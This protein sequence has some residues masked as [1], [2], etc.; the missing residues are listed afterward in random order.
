MSNFHLFD[1]TNSIEHELSEGTTILGRGQDCDI[2][3]IS[4]SVSRKHAQLELSEG[5]LTFVDLGSSNGSFVN[6]QPAKSP[7]T[8]QNGDELVMGELNFAVSI[9]GAEAVPTDDDDDD[10]T[11]MIGGGGAGPSEIPS[12]WSE[13]AGLEQA[14][15]TQ[16]GYFAGANEDEGAEAYRTGKLTLPPTGN[17]PRLVGL[18]GEILGQVFE[19]AGNGPGGTWKLGRE[20][21]SVDVVINHASVSGQHAQIVNEGKRWKVVNWM[22]TNGTFVNDQKGL[23][24]YLQS[25]DV[26]RMGS[27]ELAFELPGK[28]PSGS[29]HKDRQKGD[30]FLGWLRRLFGKG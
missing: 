4:S 10:A 2:R 12:T 18:N 6:G 7:V 27:A 30:G 8:L 19:L 1:H 28:G 11:Q 24:T 3:L 25:G 5:T 21:D 14:S 20:A 17:A 16:L 29:E 9:A 13:S 26:I 15:G 23:S 22:S